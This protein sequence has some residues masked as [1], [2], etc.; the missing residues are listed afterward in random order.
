MTLTTRP[1]RLLLVEFNELFERHLCRHSQFGINVLHLIALFAIWY[2]VYGLLALAVRLDGH[3]VGA[4]R[5]LA[6]AYPAAVAAQCA[7]PRTRG[8]RSCFSPL[9]L[10]GRFDPACRNRRGGRMSSSFR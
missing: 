4:R 6:V 1:M 5:P 8:D 7:D 10:A 2:A 9:I 3:R